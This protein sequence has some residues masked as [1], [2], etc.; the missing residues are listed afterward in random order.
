MFDASYWFSKALDLGGNYTNPASNTDN[1]QV[2][3]QSEGLLNA[4]LKGPSPFDQSHA[5][6]LRG[7]WEK[8]HFTLSAVVLAKT[9]TPFDVLSGSDGPGFGN[10]DG[11][12]GDRPNLLDPSILGRTLGDPDTSRALLPRTAFAYI[13]P[14][15]TRGNLGH[16]VF[17][18]GGIH[19]VN[20]AL[21]REWTAGGTRTITLRAES[22]NFFNS[23]QFAE[24]GKEL[25]SPNFGMITNT[26]NDGRTFRFLV[27]FG[28]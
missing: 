16:D 24:P 4:D 20:L 3:S 22:I 13:R 18:R 1:G 10:V 15:D 28:F 19:N 9:G 21:A 23:P 27:R 12:N 7:A 26:L 17:R 14:T 2:R 8:A 11:S 25:T 6:L 5:F